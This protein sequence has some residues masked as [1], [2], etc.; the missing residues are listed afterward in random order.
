M[1]QQSDNQIEATTVESGPN[2]GANSRNGVWNRPLRNRG[3]VN[4]IGKLNL[5]MY[6]CTS[7]CCSKLKSRTPHYYPDFA[8][9]LTFGARKI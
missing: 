6:E 3:T 9:K 2:I 1:V 4:L 5:T 8:N 7:F